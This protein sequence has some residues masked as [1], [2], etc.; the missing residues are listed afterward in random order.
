K[1]TYYSR[2]A[3]DTMPAIDIE[4][5]YSTD[6]SQVGIAAG[7]MDA[8]PDDTWMMQ[9]IYFRPNNAAQFITVS[10]MPN[11]PNVDSGLIYLDDFSIQEATDV[12]SVAAQNSVEVMPNPATDYIIVTGDALEGN[13]VTNI[14][15]IAGHKMQCQK[16]QKPNGDMIIDVSNLSPGMY[17]LHLTDNHT[18]I[19][20]KIVVAR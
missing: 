20:K 6:S 18:N 13:T 4:I 15:D 5:G 2:A 17:L 10:G 19:V 16:E 1:I 9:T 8:P 14:S 12:S 3:A 11:T 7:R